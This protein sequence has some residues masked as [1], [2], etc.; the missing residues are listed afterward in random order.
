MSNVTTYIHRD[1][2]RREEAIFSGKAKLEQPHHIIYFV[3]FLMDHRELHERQ[4]VD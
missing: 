2:Q 4:A 3:S 1:R